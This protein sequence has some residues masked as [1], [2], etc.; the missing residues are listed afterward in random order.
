LI[1]R[2]IFVQEE[3]PEY[4]LEYDKIIEKASQER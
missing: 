3:R 2:G 4:C 1:E